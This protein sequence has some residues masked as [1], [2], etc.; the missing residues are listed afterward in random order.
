MKVDD[1]HPL[2]A[3]WQAELE[4]LARQPDDATDLSDIPET[5]DW[6]KAVRGRHYLRRAAALSAQVGTRI[7]LPKPVAQ[8]YAAVAE[9]EQ[10]YKGRKF[11]PDGHLVGSIG[12]VIAAEVFGLELYDMSRPGH[13]ARD[14]EGRD[15]QIKLTAGRSVAMYAISDRLLVLR[16]VSP[17]EAEVA[18]D[19]PGK[20]AWD[21]ARV[22]GKNGQRVISLAKLRSIAAAAA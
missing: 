3:D 5:T 19:G 21:G 14:A 16:I 6:S 4:T 13:D 2:P 1:R 10:T 7:A 8:I 17:Q 12:E 18:Y 9:L 20:P 15:V 22:P 11:T